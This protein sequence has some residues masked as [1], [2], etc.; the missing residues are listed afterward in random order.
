[1]AASLELYSEVTSSGRH[2]II[3]LD[4]GHMLRARECIRDGR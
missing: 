1:M 4:V 2:A 3:V